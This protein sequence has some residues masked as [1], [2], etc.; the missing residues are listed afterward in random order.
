[1]LAQWLSHREV[2]YLG[3]TRDNLQKRVYLQF[4]TGFHPLHQPNL[5]GSPKITFCKYLLRWILLIKDKMNKSFFVLNLWFVMGFKRKPS[6]AT[7]AH[8]W[9]PSSSGG[10]D[11][12]DHCS[13]PAWANSS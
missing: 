5:L 13:K 11:Q 1:M 8:A 9:N 7:V 12:E 3:K 10:R 4:S 2:M 6:R